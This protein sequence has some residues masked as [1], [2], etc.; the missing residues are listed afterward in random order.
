MTP[1]EHLEKIKGS[2]DSN[3]MLRD[4]EDTTPPY[5]WVDRPKQREITLGVIALMLTHPSLGTVAFS[6][7][8]ATRSLSAS[9]GDMAQEVATLLTI[10]ETLRSV[11]EESTQR[12]MWN[13]MASA[14]HALVHAIEDYLH[15]VESGQVAATASG[16]DLLKWQLEYEARLEAAG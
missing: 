11:P 15:E 8:K 10:E 6:G 1:Q 3:V 12:P 2:L 4:P 9:R 13:E 14:C 16:Y 7:W 5:R